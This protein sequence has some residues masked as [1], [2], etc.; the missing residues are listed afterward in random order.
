MN[1]DPRLVSIFRKIEAN[2]NKMGEDLLLMMRHPDA[3]LDHINQARNSYRYAYTS[4][5]D[6]RYR[7]QARYPG[8]DHPW[9]YK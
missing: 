6:A 3:T 8:Y 7:M 1:P 9:S 4:F 2:L 5:A